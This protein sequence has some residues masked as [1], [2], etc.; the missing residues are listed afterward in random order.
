VGTH[1]ENPGDHAEYYLQATSCRGPP[2][3]E[4]YRG[5]LHVT[6]SM[7]PTPLEPSPERGS[8]HVFLFTGPFPGYQLQGTHSRVR[9]PRDPRGNTISGHPTRDRH[10][11]TLLGSPSRPPTPGNLTRDLTQRPTSKDLSNASP[12]EKPST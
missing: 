1:R 8:F 2:L 10:Q 7:R 11:G 3:G 12:P 5:Q 9:P 4:T 6:Q